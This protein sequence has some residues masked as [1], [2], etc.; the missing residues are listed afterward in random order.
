[1]VK[2]MQLQYTKFHCILNVLT[3][4]TKI[5]IYIF[6]MT[7]LQ[8][9]FVGAVVERSC[10]IW[11]F[12]PF[13]QVHHNRTMANMVSK[14]VMANR[15]NHNKVHL[16]IMVTKEGHHPINPMDNRILATKDHQGDKV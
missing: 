8:M 16:A 10:L 1:M 2:Y 11:N 15:A 5:L 4:S 9:C 6:A 13:F 7:S 14:E 3:V 12:F